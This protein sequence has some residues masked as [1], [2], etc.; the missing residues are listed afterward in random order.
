MKQEVQMS[1][2]WWKD[3]RLDDE[4]TY[5]YLLNPIPSDSL[6]FIHY[7]GKERCDECGKYSAFYYRYSHY[8]YTIDGYD[9]LD[10]NTYWKCEL[11]DRIK[12]RWKK[13]KR[14]LFPKHLIALS[15]KH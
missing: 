11:K 12:R 5:D 14:K 4:G 2:F 1:K 6:Q 8:F 7:S 3:P 9:S 10:S 13:W 15:K